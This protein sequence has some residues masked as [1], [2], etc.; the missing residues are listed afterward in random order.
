MTSPGKNSFNAIIIGNGCKLAQLLATLTLVRF[1]MPFWCSHLKTP[2]SNILS[3]P[4]P[5]ASYK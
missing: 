1:E 3:V 2:F 4:R 5:I